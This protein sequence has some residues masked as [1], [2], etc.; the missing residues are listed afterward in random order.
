MSSDAT[1]WLCNTISR[2]GKAP[3]V[4]KESRQYHLPPSLCTASC[5]RI[6]R[7]RSANIE[8]GV[9]AWASPADGSAGRPR[10]R[11]LPCSTFHIRGHGPLLF[12][13]GRR[14]GHDDSVPTYHGRTRLRKMSVPTIARIPTRSRIRGHEAPLLN[15]CRSTTFD[16]TRR[17]RGADHAAEDVARVAARVLCD[18]SQRF[19]S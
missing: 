8:Q 17:R 2:T 7:P 10:G 15:D 18:R 6:P 3:I 13:A 9:T 1:A 5:P 4:G 16:D 14:S 11:I 12:S 19:A